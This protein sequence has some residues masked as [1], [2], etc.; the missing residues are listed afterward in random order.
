MSTSTSDPYQAAAE[1]DRAVLAGQ[2]TYRDRAAYRPA[3]E[4]LPA[5]TAPV[6]PLPART[7]PSGLAARTA[8]LR[9]EQDSAR[10]MLA[11]LSQARRLRSAGG[12]R[13]RRFTSGR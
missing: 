1:R 9:A 8:A 7:A 2:A 10:A 12:V 11:P 13:A 3:D 5:R 4:P 6:A